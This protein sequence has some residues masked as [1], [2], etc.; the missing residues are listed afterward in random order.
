[1][2][3]HG[4]ASRWGQWQSLRVRLPLTI[5][6]VVIVILGVAL[7]AAYREVEAAL[8]AAGI[9]RARAASG[10]VASMMEGQL[11]AMNA[12]VRL[13]AAEPALRD[14]LKTRDS[15]KASA[16]EVELRKLLRGTSPRTV[17]LWDRANRRVLQVQLAGPQGESG[18]QALPPAEAPASE[19]WQP[20]RTTDEGAFL[21][22][23]A[24]VSDLYP[25]HEALG[26]V[27]ASSAFAVNPPGLFSRLVGGDATVLL[28]NRDGRGL[29]DLETSR[30]VTGPGVIPADGRY[31]RDGLRRVVAASSISDTPFD[32]RIELSDSVI[33]ASGRRF[34]QRMI[35]FGVLAAIASAILIRTLT[36][37]EMRPLA[38]LTAATEAMAAGDYS[39]HIGKFRHDE[40]GRLARAFDAMTTKVAADI[41]ERERIAR[42]LQENEERLRYTLSA[43]RVG[44]WQMDLGTGIVEWSETMGPLFGVS[45]SALPS[46]RDRVLEVIHADDREAVSSCLMRDSGD[47][48]EHEIFFRALQPDGDHKWVVGRSRLA[49]DAA[50]VSR[51]VGVCI[52]VTEQKILEQQLRQALKMD[53]IGKLAGGV[54]HDFN[55]LLTAI[56]G[57]AT[58]L[59]EGFEPGDPRRS[60]VD[61]ILQAGKRAA[62]LTAQLLAFSRQQLVQPIVVNVKSAVDEAM[63]LLRRLIGENIQ[64]QTVY[65]ADQ[66]KVRVDP[67]QLQQILMNLA[68]NARDAMPEGG[69]LTIE[70]SNAELDA[71]YGGQHI[72]INPGPYVLIAVSDTGVGMS[73]AVRM[74]LFEPF[75]TTKPRGEGTGLGLATVYGAVKQ[76]GGYVW[77][78]SEPGQGS[79][80]KVYLPRVA[81]DQ[82]AAA[83]PLPVLQPEKGSET[84]LLVEDEDGV[85]LLTRMILERAGYRVI[86]AAS[87]EEAEQTH[88]QFAGSIALLITDVVLPGSSGPDLYRR[89]SIRDRSLKVLYMSGYTD[90]AVFRTGRLEQ[91][92][93][94]VQKPFTAVELQRKIRETLES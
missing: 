53:A 68:I 3:T 15:A 8:V 79:N 45:S 81:D 30:G 69:R 27:A 43:A 24:L 50:G 78:Y 83:A 55:N 22:T 47:Q 52:D 90:D 86:L 59:H 19:G 4:D 80:F 44:T 75:F 70:I 64:L 36:I 34:L 41:T 51:L 82:P 10:Q 13:I 5:S 62:D 18:P 40:V 42:A 49:T 37:R 71:A 7:F 20:M 38:E 89:L 67:G 92:V 2:A 12:Q 33:L 85:R 57:F 31:E 74:R 14:Y 72:A 63:V 84:I 11:R 35:F 73:E 93:S 25:T 28:A 58:L 21:S 46:Q 76:A 32:I 39:R 88:L 16:A 1:M 56:L 6:L 54:A 26:Y 17:T 94:F 48:Q 23:S 66:A 61:A 60:Q 87:A 9:D 65:T 77:A 29:V 91:G